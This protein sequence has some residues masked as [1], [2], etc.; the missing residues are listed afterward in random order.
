MIPNVLCGGSF[1]GILN[2]LKRPT[3]HAVRL[4][5]TPQTFLALVAYVVVISCI[6]PGKHHGPMAITLFWM[7]SL[8]GVHPLGSRT[9]D[10]MTVT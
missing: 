6:K 8:R 1:Y 10:W 4:S 3:C 7:A 9:W 5:E 2:V